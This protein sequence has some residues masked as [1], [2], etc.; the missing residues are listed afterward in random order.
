M[1][2][3]KVLKYL[4]GASGVGRQATKVGEI[5][6]IPKV[7]LKL[8]GSLAVDGAV[9]TGKGFNKIMPMTKKT[10]PNIGNLWTG[11]REGRGMI[12]VAGV[13]GAGY[14]GYSTMKQ[15][16]LA[17]KIGEVSYGGAAPIMD[18]DGVASRPQAPTLGA[19]GNMVFGLHN[20]RKG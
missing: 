3:S 12:A 18:A 10:D 4:S 17:P 11:R 19:G 20:A 7:P 14:M 8:A 16:A 6:N 13:A 15:T 5:A 1:A 2:K 9:A